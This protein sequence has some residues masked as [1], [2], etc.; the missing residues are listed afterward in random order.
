MA[1]RNEINVTMTRNYT[2]PVSRTPA[3][4]YSID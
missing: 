2:M 1:L 4:I 3:R